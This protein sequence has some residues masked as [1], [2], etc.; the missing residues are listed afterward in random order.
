MR[1]S[2]NG[3]S[4]KLTGH[5]LAR[6]LPRRWAE[7]GPKVGTV[8]TDRFDE[9]P[10]DIAA[11]RAPQSADLVPAACLA[12]EDVHPIRWLREEALL[13]Q[14]ELAARAGVSLRTIWSVEH[15]RDCR[16]PT[17]RRILQAL[18][19]PKHRHHE[20]FPGGNRR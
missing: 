4:A 16:T 14:E 20:L 9:I 13:T 17:K 15:G 19:V 11:A 12:Q 1:S 7:K 10:V 3:R 6:R 5:L 18:G 2:A 8:T